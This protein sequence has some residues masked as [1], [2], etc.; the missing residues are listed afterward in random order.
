MYTYVMLY[1]QDLTCIVNNTIPVFNLSKC[2]ISEFIV[3][4][5]LML[6]LSL[7]TVSFSVDGIF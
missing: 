6:K 3:R 1:M 7:Q 2:L 5:Y 4:T